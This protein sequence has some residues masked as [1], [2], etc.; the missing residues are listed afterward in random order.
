MRKAINALNDYGFME[1]E[2]FSTYK[3]ELCQRILEIATV[4]AIYRDI[5]FTDISRD[6]INLILEIGNKNSYEKVRKYFVRDSFI[7]DSIYLNIINYMTSS[8]VD[9]EDILTMV[10]EEIKN[11]TNKNILDE[12]YALKKSIIYNLSLDI[13]QS[14]DDIYIKIKDIICDDSKSI[15]LSEFIYLIGFIR[16]FDSGHS[17]SYEKLVDEGAVRYID[18]LEK[19]NRLYNYREQEE[20]QS[21]FSFSKKAKEH[22]LEKKQNLILSKYK[23]DEFKDILSNIYLE[24]KFSRIDLYALNNVDEKYIKGYILEDFEINRL[25]IKVLQRHFINVENSFFK[26]FGEK[27]IKIYQDLK[28][29]GNDSQKIQAKN[30][31]KTL[32]ISQ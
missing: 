28:E 22:Y 30:I 14:L 1:D 9:K 11:N 6:N 18:Y 27:V 7:M 24:D 21:I 8:I 23:K 15:S 2:H 4:K 32:S 17:V 19:N 5:D 20:L 25:C 29:N 31:L 3:E 26:E 12:I 10:E 13:K 16:K